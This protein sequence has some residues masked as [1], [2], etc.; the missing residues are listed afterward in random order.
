MCVKDETWQNKV[1]VLSETPT[2]LLLKLQCQ[3]LWDIMLLWKQPQLALL[4]SF[5][6][7]TWCSWWKKFHHM[8][9]T[10]GKLNQYCATYSKGTHTQQSELHCRSLFVIIK[11]IPLWEGKNAL[12]TLLLRVA[13]QIWT[14]KPATAVWKLQEGADANLK[15]IQ[16]MFT[17]RD[18]Y[19]K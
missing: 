14:L 1:T 9:Y 7:H 3:N 16:N 5:G 8:Q 19:F 11:A 18:V 15:K 13:H 10:V 6:K 2:V 12:F 4:Y 17:S